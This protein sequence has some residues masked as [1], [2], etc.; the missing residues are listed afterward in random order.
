MME[1]NPLLIYIMIYIGTVCYTIASYYHLQLKEWTF[2]KA[3]FI[4]ICFVVIEYQFSLR[5]NYL[6]NKVLKINPIQILVATTVFCF[7][8]VMIL[9]KL[10]L[11]NP[12]KPWR[13]FV[14]LILM[15]GAI[16]VSNL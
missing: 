4:A 3:F 11:K 12:I 9:N 10:V 14:S 15:V 13:E 6:A 5:G 2:L 8:N 7:I 16:V 1:T